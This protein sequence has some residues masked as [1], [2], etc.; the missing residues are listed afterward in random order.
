VEKKV[1]SQQVDLTIGGQLEKYLQQSQMSRATDRQKLRYALDG[2][3]KQRV[4]E[5]REIH[6]G[7]QTF[8]LN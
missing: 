6:V 1:E 2:A 5:R 3:E 7:I 8:L 4:P